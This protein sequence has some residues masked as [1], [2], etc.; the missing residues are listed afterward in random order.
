MQVYGN[1]NFAAVPGIVCLNVVEQVAST[2]VD[3]SP[4]AYSKLATE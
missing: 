1:L 3:F 4:K 2:V